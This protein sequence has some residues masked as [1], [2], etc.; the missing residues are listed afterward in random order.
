MSRLTARERYESDPTFRMLVN[1]QLDII[2]HSHNRDGTMFTPTE[3]RE[4]AML[5][6]EIFET[7]H[8]RPM[9]HIVDNAAGRPL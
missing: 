4:A 5:A 3:L 2:E 9:L 8:I 1:V 6:A 7:R